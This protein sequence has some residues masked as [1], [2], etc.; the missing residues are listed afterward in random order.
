MHV[1]V[2]MKGKYNPNLFSPSTMW[3]T[4]LMLSGMEAS[5]FTCWAVI[6]PQFL[7]FEQLETLSH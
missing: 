4:E 1:Y 3:K 7:F 2:F 5:T 6:C